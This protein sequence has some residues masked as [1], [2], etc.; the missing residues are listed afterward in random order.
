MPERKR[1]VHI[2]FD[3]A[4]AEWIAP[5][6]HNKTL[7]YESMTEFIVQAVREKL[8]YYLQIGMH[9]WSSGRHPT[10]GESVRTN[11]APVL[12]SI[13]LVGMLGLLAVLSPLTRVSGLVVAPSP[14]NWDFL[15]FYNT[16]WFL[17]DFIIYSIIFVSLAYATIGRMLGQRGIGIG[18]GLFLAVAMA[19]L[20]AG[21]GFAIRDLGI[22][23]A[24]FL[25][26]VMGATL[27]H[28]FRKLQF[29]VFGAASVTLLLVYLGIIIMI[30]PLYT[31]LHAAF[32][33]VGFVVAIV[34]MIGL[35]HVLARFFK[36]RPVWAQLEQAP[37]TPPEVQALYPELKEEQRIIQTYLAGITSRAKKDTKAIATE[38]IYLY[39]VLSKFGDS[40]ESRQL[41]SK[42]LKGLLPEEQDLDVQL[43]AVRGLIE[44]IQT[45]DA[46]VFGTKRALIQKLGR[47]DRQQVQ[48]ELQEEVRKLRI[49]E[50]LGDLENKV[51]T[52]KDAL[53][54]QVNA[55][56]Q[57]LNQGDV[58]RA[59][60][61]LVEAIKHANAATEL[62]DQTKSLND[63][64]DQ[65][66]QK[67]LEALTPKK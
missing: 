61:S 41:I 2:S 63:L 26:L 49:E 15:A 4:V 67:E 40:A 6:V 34:F 24:A 28:V 3:K 43:R 51:K 10:K 55:A 19:G 29:D 42:K 59:K 17:I 16:Y 18:V 22:L 60:Q 5:L 30:P 9:P 25:T 45:V 52:Y 13:L 35:Y 1:Y 32:P 53:L 21:T 8:D 54:T 23:A 27:Y 50:Q 20:E 57:A 65:L 37:P 38:L 58:A 44:R 11:A 33:M 56:V 66:T 7:G 39:H 47:A 64:L 14:V 48:K 31:W 62:L 36:E 12:A 46:K